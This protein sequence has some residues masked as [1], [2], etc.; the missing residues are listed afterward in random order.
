M[1]NFANFEDSDSSDIEIE[2]GI[3][4]LQN[5]QNKVSEFFGCLKMFK[6]GKFTSFKLVKINF[7]TFLE[8]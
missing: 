2:I 8:V 6:K 3:F 4:H 1:P 7:L 5:D